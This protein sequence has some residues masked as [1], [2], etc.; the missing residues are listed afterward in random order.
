M[1]SR[2]LL[3]TNDKPKK[4]KHTIKWGGIHFSIFS[5]GDF[6]FLGDLSF[7]SDVATADWNIQWS[8]R[9]K[10]HKVHASF[11]DLSSVKKK[12]MG[13][14]NIDLTSEIF[15]L[16]FPSKWSSA[17]LAGG[18][19]VFFSPTSQNK[20]IYKQDSAAQWYLLEKLSHLKNKE[21]ET[22]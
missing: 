20:N 18:G 16:F 8:R 2:S 4:K 9:T 11:S 21:E 10:K 3:W 5:R 7:F 6:F 12:L 14:S 15:S 19:L 17:L 22:W 1:A 13:I